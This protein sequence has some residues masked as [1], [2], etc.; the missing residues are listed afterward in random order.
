[1]AEKMKYVTHHTVSLKSHPDFNEAWL[2]ARIKD[3]SS[4]IGLGDVRVI[5]HERRHSGAGR[6]DLL[7]YSEDD[8]R[9]F[10]VEIML[11][12]TDPSHIIRT[13]EYWDIERRRYPAYE[14]IAVLIAEDITSRFLNVLSLM[15]GSIP[16]VAIQLCALQVGDQIVLNFVRVLDQTE[17]R[18]DDTAEE[19]A[20]KQVDRNYWDTLVGSPVMSICDKVL[21]LVNTKALTRFEMNF[22]ESYI[23]LK[24]N[25]AVNNFISF[26]PR[27]KGLVHVDFR[28]L[29]ATDLFDLFKGSGLSTRLTNKRYVSVTLTD[30]LLETHVKMFEQVI[31]DVA[32][33]NGVGK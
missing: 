20:G 25:G 32:N 13:I 28:T 6:L 2:H 30:E 15:S 9:R 21:K 11:G 8:N 27:K 22:L 33:D 23:G 19:V 14:H 5:D 24:Q 3:D 31:D 16:F 29:L 4:I 26:H 10:E 7:L 1:M 17:L 18:L 12:A